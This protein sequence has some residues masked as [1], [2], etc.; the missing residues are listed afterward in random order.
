MRE[1]EE[2]RRQ[3]REKD[4]SETP[5]RHARDTSAP[6]PMRAAPAASQ[7]H[8]FTGMQVREKD[9]LVRRT[10]EEMKFFKL[11]LKNREE[12]FNQRFGGGPR[13]GGGLPEIT[14]DH[15]RSPSSSKL[16]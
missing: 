15:P 14:R 12:N 5:L 16:T 7:L 4:T 3:V 10:Y 6:L 2:L 11:E 1:I 8:I 9:E 13:V